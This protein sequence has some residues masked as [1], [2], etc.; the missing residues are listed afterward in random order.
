MTGFLIGL[1]AAL[2][3]LVGL[4]LLAPKGW[5]TRGY[6]ILVSIVGVFE[7]LRQLLDVSD[8]SWLSPQVGGGIIL[9]TGIVTLILRQMTSTPAGEK[10]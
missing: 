8:L 6:G 9:G 5:R 7:G 2:L 1:G 4:Y 3:I 10:A